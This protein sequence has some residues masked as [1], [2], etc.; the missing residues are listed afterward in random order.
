MGG[1]PTLDYSMY[2]YFLN[3]QPKMILTV[4]LRLITSK[5][6]FGVDLMEERKTGYNIEKA[7]NVDHIKNVNCILINEPDIDLF[8]EAFYDIYIKP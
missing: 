2:V 5:C 1:I 7:L 3:N 8:A 4:K 6:I